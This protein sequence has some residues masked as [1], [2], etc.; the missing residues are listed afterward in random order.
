MVSE[1]WSQ[2]MQTLESCSPCRKRRAAVQ[3]WL[4]ITSQKKNRTRGAATVFH[5][6]CAPVG[7]EEPKN[8]PL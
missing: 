2:R 5:N 8:I 7:V 3:Q 4:C 1:A 6:N